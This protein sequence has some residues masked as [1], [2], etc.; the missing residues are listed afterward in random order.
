MVW[1]YND[2]K[3]NLLILKLGVG[4]LQ[5]VKKWILKSMVETDFSIL[6]F[7]R[8]FLFISENLRTKSKN[9]SQQRSWKLS[10]WHASLSTFQLY[11]QA[12]SIAWKYNWNVDKKTVVEKVFKLISGD[13]R[14]RNFKIL[15]VINYDHFRFTGAHGLNFKYLHHP[16]SQWCP[17]FV[18]DFYFVPSAGLDHRIVCDRAHIIKIVSRPNC[19]FLGRVWLIG[20]E[21]SIE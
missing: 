17:H 3:I 8:I 5:R 2:L 20:F 14:L 18:S 19:N 13:D 11:F 4:F 12:P 16:S 15:W 7:V 9:G 10:Q 6:T 21:I 1:C